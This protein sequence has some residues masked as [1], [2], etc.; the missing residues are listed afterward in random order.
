MTALYKFRKKSIKDR[1][2][3]SL[4]WPVF[5]VDGVS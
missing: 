4:P 5:P 1:E 2:G 3:R